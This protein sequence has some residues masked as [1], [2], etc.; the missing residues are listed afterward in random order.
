MSYVIHTG[1]V[2]GEK[3]KSTFGKKPHNGRSKSRN[4]KGN[5]KKNVISDSRLK[6]KAIK[7]PEYTDWF[8]EVLQPP[9]FVCCTY[10]GIQ[11][12]HIKEHS[13]DERDDQ[14]LIPLCW[15]H[16]HGTE[17]SPHGTPVKFKEVYPMNVQYENAAEMFEKY[18]KGML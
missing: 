11:A 18:K 1:R 8:H 4:R 16:H 9:C 2:K 3:T 14:F 7:M 5:T 6:D 13:T 15:E 12:H 17:L 10:L